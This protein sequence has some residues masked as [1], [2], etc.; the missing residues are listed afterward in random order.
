VIALTR[1]DLC[2]ASLGALLSSSCREERSVPLPARLDRLAFGSCNKQD[3]L[4]THWRHIRSQ[5]P[6][7][8]LWLGD[9][10][11]ADDA[12]PQVREAQYEK[13]KD[14]KDYRS[15]CEQSFV[16]GTWDDH[17]YGSNDA[18][19]EYP[20]KTESQRLFLNFLGE[21]KDS[22]RRQ[23]E[24]IYTSYE[25]GRGP[26][27]IKIILTDFRTFKERP[28]RRAD[29]LGKAQWSWLRQE[30]ED[31]SPV[32]KIL[33]SSVQVLTPFTGK[34]NWSTFP[35]SKSRLLALLDRS[36]S[37]VLILS[38]DRHAAEF[39]VFPLASGRKVFEM[40]SSGLTHATD[41]GNFNLWREGEQVTANNFG[42]LTL[43]W[44]DALDPQLA[45]IHL[46]AFSPQTGVLLTQTSHRLP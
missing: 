12:T 26:Q 15:L 17:D 42:L 43:D 40:T 30:L 14:H 45:G 22:P 33:A 3:Q 31:P 2:L 39:S 11:Y 46:A 41:T 23:Q 8:W 16:L 34:E 7:G 1:R 13:L 5:Q 20:G 6:Q 32:L 36:P 28:D 9:S 18:G 24:G 29:P 27:K 38:G 21:A 37:P 35:E 19:L 4:Q 10:I 44:T 25:I